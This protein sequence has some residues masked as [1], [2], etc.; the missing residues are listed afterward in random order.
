MAPGAH[1]VLHWEYSDSLRI[2][3]WLF[4]K[5]RVPVRWQDEGKFR[6][7]G[8]DLGGG[9][10]HDRRGGGCT[11]QEGGL[12]CTKREGG[13]TAQQGGV[14]RT[15]GGGVQHKRG[16]ISPH[17]R[18]VGVVPHKRGVVPQNRGEGTPHNSLNSVSY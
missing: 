8:L 3:P 9:A 4:I 5:T 7:W 15:T 2:L 1:P 17:N 18:G 6:H 14:Y 10:P 12:Y 16:G 11:V 13:R